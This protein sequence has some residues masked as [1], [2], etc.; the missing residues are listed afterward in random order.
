MPS[1]RPRGLGGEEGVEQAALGRLVHPSA[2]AGSFQIHELP[3]RRDQVR[4]A[5]HEVCR[6]AVLNAYREGDD[7]ACVS[8]RLRGVGEEVHDDLLDVADACRDGREIPPK[9]EIKPNR[10]RDGGAEPG[11]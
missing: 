2:G 3:G 6:V 4:A 5:A 10:L 11:G 9:P 1:P 8:D 7:A